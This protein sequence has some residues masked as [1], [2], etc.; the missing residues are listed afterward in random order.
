MKKRLLMVAVMFI[1]LQLLAVVASGVQLVLAECSGSASKALSGPSRTKCTS[2]TINGNTVYPTLAPSVLDSSF[3]TLWY[4][5]TVYSAAQQN[6]TSIVSSIDVPNS[7][8]SRDDFYY[9]ILSCYD[10][11]GSYDQLGFCANNGFWELAYSYT[12]GNPAYLSS[13]RWDANAMTLSQGTTYTF[14]MTVQNGIAFFVAYQGSTMVWSQHNSTGGN[15]LI[16]ANQD[17]YWGS[18]GP[19]YTDY[20]EIHNTST[21]GGAPGFNFNFHNQYWVATNGSSHAATWIKYT[22]GPVPDGVNVVIAGDYVVIGNP[23]VPLLYPVDVTVNSVV[24]VPPH[25]SVFQVYHHGMRYHGQPISMNYTVTV[26]RT[27]NDAS[28][29]VLYVEVGLNRT[30][31][32]NA[33]DIRNI[34]TGGVYLASGGNFTDVFTWNETTTMNPGNY[35]ITG[36]ANS[37]SDDTWEMN[38]ADNQ[39]TNDTVQAKE[40]IGDINGDGDV[41]ILDA[42][43]MGNA[44]LSHPGD[45]RW[46]PDADLNKDGNIDIL[47]EIL[48]R[49]HFGES[50]GGG[51]GGL[52]SGRPANGAA[53]PATAGTPSVV[54]DPSQLTVFK[55]EVFTVNVKVTGVTDLCGWEFKLYWNSTVLNCTNA[56]VQTPAEWQNNTQNYG[57][58]L[59]ANYNATNALYWEG[60]SATYPDSSFNG[61]MT[62][63]TLTF[64]AMQPGTTP[65]TLTDTILG[66]STAQPIAYTASSGSVNVYYGRYM[67]SDTQTINGLSAYK[68]N[69]PESTSSAYVTQSGSGAGASW[70]IR[71]W[72]RHSNGVEQEISLDGQTGTP[73]AVVWRAR[74]SGMQSGTVSVAQTGLQLADSL[75]VRVYVQV[76]E[77]DWTL[78]ATFTTEQLHATTLQAATWTVYYYTYAFWNRLTDWTTCRLY[79][80][81][82]TYN[83]QIQNLQYT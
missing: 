29:G 40:L 2:S 59:E 67:R 39:L 68:L 23:G 79:W 17:P 14:N 41:N 80:G 75:V 72:V 47:D 22:F 46:N 6:A 55:G 57:P 37:L 5:G 56:V 45:P 38:P 20:E 54:V 12:V 42:I 34:G 32:N 18:G 16:V 43:Q 49:L 61:S 76:G 13:Y 15:Y 73:T 1:F 65:L 44:Y 83:S 52:G 66:N 62:I 10:N 78:C 58:G 50:I 4:A 24:P 8:P 9:V 70:G 81:A 36:F 53:Q 69:I 33:S 64:Q 31:V 11:N 63:A 27:D 48:L 3:S 19:D 7:T 51:F 30:N 82:T 35:S 60:Q 21:A 74:G 26:S 77:S 71:A 28:V 25:Y